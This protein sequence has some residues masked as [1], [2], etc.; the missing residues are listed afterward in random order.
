MNVVDINMFYINIKF[1]QNTMQTLIGG[2]LKTKTAFINL[3][4][5]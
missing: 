1:A 2:E 4:A 5:G 3:F